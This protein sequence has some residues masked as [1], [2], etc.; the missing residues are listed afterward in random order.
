M[1]PFSVAPKRT[2]LRGFTDRGMTNGG[3][4]GRIFSQDPAPRIP[5]D[6]IYGKEPHLIIIIITAYRLSSLTDS[7]D[8]IK[9]GSWKKSAIIHDISADVHSCDNERTGK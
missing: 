8:E 9:T 7:Y 6:L 2:V 1:P 5:D 4:F 3:R